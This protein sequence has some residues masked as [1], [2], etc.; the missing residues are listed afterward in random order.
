MQY[1]SMHEH[2]RLLSLTPPGRL[3]DLSV[4]LWMPSTK[5]R[6]TPSTTCALHQRFWVPYSYN[7]LP[8]SSMIPL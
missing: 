4:D 6:M 8:L 7:L 3:V 1:E 5:F 2:L